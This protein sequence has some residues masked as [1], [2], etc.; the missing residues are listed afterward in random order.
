MNTNLFNLLI[1]YLLH[2]NHG[3]VLRVHVLRDHVLHVLI[4]E[5][6]IPLLYFVTQDLL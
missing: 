6:L 1:Y 3:H 4:R 2:V 5:F